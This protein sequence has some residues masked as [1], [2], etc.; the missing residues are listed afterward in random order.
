MPV[1]H[2]DRSK[3]ADWAK[4]CIARADDHAPTEIRLGKVIRQ[5]CTALT[6]CV[7]VAGEGLDVASFRHQD[8]E[9]TATRC[10]ICEHLEKTF[11]D[12]QTRRMRG[13]LKDV[14]P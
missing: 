4:R 8:E 11:D 2:Q 9:I 7:Q 10:S 12:G 13:E 14:H 6:S 1:E 3:I 5:E